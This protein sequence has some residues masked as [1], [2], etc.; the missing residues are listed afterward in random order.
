MKRIQIIFLFLIALTTLSVVSDRE[1]TNY[2]SE[3]DT[4]FT[5]GLKYDFGL[6]EIS[7]ELKRDTS[8]EELSIFTIQNA[9]ITSNQQ[10]IVKNISRQIFQPASGKTFYRFK[11][12]NLNNQTQQ[13]L[14]PSRAPPLYS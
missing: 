2:Y 1:D 12:N 5:C 3:Y 13:S 9:V 10:K 8:K 4:R 14:F 6:L 11:L 7:H